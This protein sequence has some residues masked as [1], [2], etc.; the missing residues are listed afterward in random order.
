MSLIEGIIKISFGA[1][2]NLDEG[3]RMIQREIKR[4]RKVIFNNIPVALVEKFLPFLKGKKVSVV[5]KENAHV[6]SVEED[7]ENISYYTADIHASHGNKNVNF[8]CI[9]LPNIIFDITWD[10]KDEILDITGLKFNK[11][12]KCN[13]RLN[14]CEYA[15]KCDQGIYIGKILRPESGSKHLLNDL[16]KAEKAIIVYVPDFFIEKMAPFFNSKDIRILLPYG[17]RVHPFVKNMPQSRSARSWITPNLK[18]YEH[19]N[20]IAGGVCFPHIH[21]GVAWKNNRILE[22]RTIEMKE[23]VH[24]MVEMY[25]A[26]WSFGKRIRF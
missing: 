7:I 17:H 26:A 14:L 9:V 25:L 15:E 18:I 5:F 8:G 16:Q 1:S 20:A 2:Y 24:C 3:I 21:Y 22:I 12:L 19:D 6:A 13:F 23:C 4:S 11:C 10:N